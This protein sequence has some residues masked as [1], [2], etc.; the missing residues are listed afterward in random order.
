MG[1]KERLLSRKHRRDNELSNGEDPMVTCPSTSCFYYI[2]IGDDYPSDEVAQRRGRDKAM[3]GTFWDE[4]DC[5]M[6]KAHDASFVKNLKPLMTKPSNE[7]MYSHVHK[8]MQVC[9]LP[10]SYSCANVSPLNSFILL[11]F[12]CWVNLYI[13]QGNI[14]TMKRSSQWLN[15]R[16]THFL[17]KMKC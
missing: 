2:I 8:I 5:T 11:C 16:Q 15:P 17:L 7:L 12:R 1:V 6:A 13:S 9:F 10:L 3:V 14:W 4:A